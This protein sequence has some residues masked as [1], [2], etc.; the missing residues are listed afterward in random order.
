MNAKWWS[1]SY[2]FSCSKLAY[3]LRFHDVVHIYEMRGH[4]RWIENNVLFM[5]FF[6]FEMNVIFFYKCF[7]LLRTM[8]QVK[9]Q[10]KYQGKKNTSMTQPKS[11]IVGMA[12]F[13][14]TYTHLLNSKTIF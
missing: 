7:Q 13:N 2:H 10:R 8:T 11:P 5:Y 4:I 9:S 1:L 14:L 6:S 3:G 12:F